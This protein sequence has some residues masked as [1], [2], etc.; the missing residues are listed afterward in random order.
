MLSAVSCML[1]K[2]EPGPKIVW[3]ASRPSPFLHPFPSPSF[4]FPLPF[5]LEV[6]IPYCGCGIWGSAQ[7]P[8]PPQR[9]AGG[10]RPPN[11]FW[12]ILGLNLRL[13]EYLMQLTD[14]VAGTDHETSKKYKLQH[15]NSFLICNS[16]KEC[17]FG[18]KLCRTTCSVREDK[19]TLSSLTEQ[20][21]LRSYQLVRRDIK[22]G[23]IGPGLS[24]STM[25]LLKKWN[26]ECVLC[27]E[28]SVKWWA[29]SHCMLRC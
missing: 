17:L 27:T 29:A 13:F 14:T 3:D 19:Q 12:C 8:L 7:A 18:C 6:G 22:R 15:K 4:P 16:E 24:W 26:G 9:A 28:M 5:P 25:W 23:F 20:V 11:A 21:I 2:A 10:A 1:Q